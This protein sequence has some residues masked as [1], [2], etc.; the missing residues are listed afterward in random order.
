MAKTSQ[1]EQTYRIKNNRKLAIG[2]TTGS[3]AA[4]A[5]KAA[6]IMLITGSKVEEVELIVPG[7]MK[8][9][10][11]VE[12]IRRG[13]N[14]VE[15]SVAKDSGDD[16]D[17]TNGIH[18][19]SRVTDLGSYSQIKGSQSMIEIDGGIG[20]G[21]VTKP[22]LDQNIGEAAINRVPRQMIQT[23]IEHIK[24]D[25]DWDHRISVLILAPEGVEIAKQTFNQRLGIQGG[26]SILGTSGIVEPMSEQALIDSICLE[27]HQRLLEQPGQLFFTPGNYGSDFCKEKYHLCMDDAIKVSN[28]MGEAIDAA[29][30]NGATKILLV[31]HI[32]KLVKIAG[33]IMNTHSKNADCRMELLV[34]AMVR[35]GVSTGLCQTV[36]ESNTTEEAVGFLIQNGCIKQVMEA[37]L[38]RVEYYLVQRSKEQIQFGIIIFSSTYGELIQNKEAMKMMQ[39]F[40]KED[41]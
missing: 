24:E 20:I 8:F 41:L 6:T 23:E 16:P 35:V 30:A 19:Y 1:Q 31:G 37:L 2:Y 32:G 12:N 22:G 36:L 29:V 21:R 17:V 7:G 40:G 28:F 25:F 14:W 33:G 9:I 34:S 18:I 10:L 27:I 5:S 15:C 38:E 39:S 4:A 13:K 26:I 11:L 3:C